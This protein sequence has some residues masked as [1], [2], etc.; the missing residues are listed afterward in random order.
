M[1]S[2]LRDKIDQALK[3]AMLAKEKRRMGTLRLVNAAIKDRRI[4]NR[5]AGKGDTV[6]DAEVMEIL[7]KMI[8]QRRDSIK[9]YEDGGRCELAEQEREE[10]AVVEEFLPAQLGEDDMRVAVEKVIEEIGAAGLKD[11]GRTMGTLKDQYAGQMDFGKASAMVKE[12]LG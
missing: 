3:E 4:Q 7:A 1:T 5:S 6:D 9:M 12:R 8:K 10:I 11:M 2:A